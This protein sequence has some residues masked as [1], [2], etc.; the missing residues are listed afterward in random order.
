M[1]RVHSIAVSVVFTT[2]RKKGECYLDNAP[3][4]GPGGVSLM[5]RNI[6]QVSKN[7]IKLF[8]LLLESFEPLGSIINNYL[9]LLC[10]KLVQHFT[11]GRPGQVDG[12]LFLLSRTILITTKTMID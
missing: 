9:I 5:D 12:F 3:D 4:P 11:T 1:K 8:L 7:H 2:N 10:L 6:C